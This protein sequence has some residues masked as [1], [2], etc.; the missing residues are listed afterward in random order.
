MS[1]FGL[2][3]LQKSRKGNDMVRLNIERINKKEIGREK[4][5]DLRGKRCNIDVI[6]V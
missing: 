3:R 1:V 2:Q 4:Q 6:R 5:D